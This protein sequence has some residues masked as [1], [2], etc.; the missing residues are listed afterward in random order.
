M[1]QCLDENLAWWNERVAHHAD[2]EFYDVEGFKSGRITL[3]PLERRELGNVDGRSLLHLQCHFGLDT[4]SWARLGAQVTGVDFS[5]EAIAL[6]RSLARELGIDATFIKSDVYD[7][8]STHEGAYDIVYTSYGVLTWLPDLT[9]WA[10]VIAHFLKPGGT[11]YIAEIHPFAYV[12]NDEEDADELEV[13]YPYFHDPEPLRFEL[14]G[15]Y[16]APE[17]RTSHK[18]TYEWSH[19]LSDVVNAVLSAGLRLEYLHEFPFA[20]FKMY[21]FLEKDEDGWWWLREKNDSIP[22]TFSLKATR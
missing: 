5:E 16:A 14:D 10:E 3:M 21:P 22:M 6:A 2:S 20:S 12:F 4:L 15:S 18:T 13:H 9:R 1:D 11:F 19:S 17:A 7:L 8:P